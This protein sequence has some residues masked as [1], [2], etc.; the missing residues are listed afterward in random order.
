MYNINGSWVGYFNS[1]AARELKAEVF[2]KKITIAREGYTIWSYFYFSSK[3]GSTTGRLKNKYS[4]KY[5]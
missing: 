1:C 2:N 5:V 3:R 4:A